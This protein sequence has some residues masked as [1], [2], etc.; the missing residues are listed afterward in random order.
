MSTFGYL[1]STVLAL[2]EDSPITRGHVVE[3]V[4]GLVRA[5][6][7]ELAFDTMCSWLFEDDLAIS[8]HYCE[9]LVVA[10][11]ELAMPGA[12]ERLDE[13]I[14]EAPQGVRPG[15]PR[16]HQYR[17]L[18]A[19]WGIVIGITAEYGPLAEAASGMPLAEATELHLAQVVQD[20]LGAAGV[21]ELARGM[22]KSLE[23]AGLA[24]PPASIRVLEVLI[25]ETDFQVEGWPRPGTSGSAGSS[26]A[27]CR[28]SRPS[29]TPRRTGT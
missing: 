16:M 27:A 10:A 11:G 8:Q 20:R 18:K 22:Q 21:R 3:D 12:V 7:V 24:D 2:L 26:A 9:R 17:V 1:A 19:A 13:L 5:G 14:P 15:E 28:R 4:R 6:E 29:S 23:L 25:V